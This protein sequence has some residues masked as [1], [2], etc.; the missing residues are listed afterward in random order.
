[1][2]INQIFP[3][4]TAA[5]ANVLSPADYEA[6]ASRNGGFSAGTA[7]SKDL[8]T[9]WRQ[10]SFVAAMIGQYIAE[11]SREDVLDNGDLAAL[12]AKFVA[13]LAASPAFT[14]TPTAPTPVANDNSTRLATTQFVRATLENVGLRPGMLLATFAATPPEGML[15]AN[16]ALVSRT[17]YARLFDAI[18]TRYGVGDGTTN[19]ALP[20]IP[21]GLALLAGSAATVGKT[22]AGAVIS[23][24]HTAGIQ[25][26]G[27]HAH[28]AWTDT[29]GG[30]DHGFWTGSGEGT[31]QSGRTANAER[32]DNYQR[33]A[34]DGAGA[35]AH[36]VGIGGDGAHTH[37]ID[38]YAA[39]GSQNL[40]AGVK[41]LIC[42]AY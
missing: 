12:Q 28:S 39:G 14:G 6:L 20:N 10:A 22:A 9:V 30:H 34:V 4:G 37:G 24:N 26:A 3:F 16:G 21:E 32:S 31:R 8:N 42:I 33:L 41:L 36:N 23:H 19:F 13:A 1:M 7:K 25:A 38:V 11:K 18:G 17:T 29:Q 35:H 27:Y 15:V 2:A 5:G 40:A